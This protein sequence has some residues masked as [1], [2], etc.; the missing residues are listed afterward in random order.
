ML[1]G[2]P[3]TPALGLDILHIQGLI[4][5][6][7]RIRGSIR[8]DAGLESPNLTTQPPSRLPVDTYDRDIYAFRQIRTFEQHSECS[9]LPRI[10]QTV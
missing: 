2:F 5:R 4:A 3:R 1:S 10:L 6:R 7:L 9:V 8:G